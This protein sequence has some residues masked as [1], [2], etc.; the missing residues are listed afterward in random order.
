MLTSS[1][2]P[3]PQKVFKFSC[4]DQYFSSPGPLEIY[5]LP[6][7]LPVDCESVPL[8]RGSYLSDVEIDLFVF[9]LVQEPGYLVQGVVAEVFPMKQQAHCGT[10]RLNDGQSLQRQQTNT[11]CNISLCFL[12]ISQNTRGFPPRLPKHFPHCFQPRKIPSNNG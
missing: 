11:T 1:L 7:W 6:G 12:Y 8:G 4:P 9:I 10:M 5:C 3:S 2:L